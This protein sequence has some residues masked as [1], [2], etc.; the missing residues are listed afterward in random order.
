MSDLVNAYF[1]PAPPFSATGKNKAE[2]PDAIALFSLERWAK[3]RNLTVLAVSNDKGWKAF[4]D[5]HERI[6]LREVL[7][8]ALSLVQKHAEEARAIVQMLFKSIENGDAPE[9]VARFDRK[10]E[11]ALFGYDVCGEADSFYSIEADQVE[12][13]LVEFRFAGDEDDYEFSVV[14]SGPHIL[15]IEVDLEVV[16]NAK[17]AFHMSIYDSTDKDHTPIGSTDANIEE[18]LAFKALVTFEREDDTAPFGL[19]KLELIDGP[20]SVNFGFVTPYYEPD[21]ELLYELP[22]DMPDDRDKDAPGL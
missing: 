11:N 18:E 3:D 15:A 7:V 21:P 1:Q 17:T 19:S 22:D 16:V 13:E 12:L 8:D 2:F 9:L 20:R 14:Q 4:A 10:L 5:V 6:D